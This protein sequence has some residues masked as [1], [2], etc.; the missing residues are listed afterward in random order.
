[1]THAG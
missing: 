1:M